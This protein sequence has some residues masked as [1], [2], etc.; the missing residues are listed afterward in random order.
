MGG[1]SL[2]AEEEVTSCGISGQ[3]HTGWGGASETAS[4]YSLS[5]PTVMSTS[6]TKGQLSELLPCHSPT[7]WQS[8]NMLEKR[9]LGVPY[10]DLT[11][12]VG[13]PWVACSHNHGE[14][15]GLS[16]TTEPTLCRMS[17]AHCACGP[18]TSVSAMAVGASSK[19]LYH[20]A[21]VTI[22]GHGSLGAALALSE[23]LSPSRDPVE[24]CVS[25]SG[26]VSLSLRL[27]PGTLLK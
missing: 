24:D 21:E 11:L 17:S 5:A 14:M 27:C 9:I 1:L 6:T 2:C 12:W 10:L 8:H 15:T 20:S 7:A 4:L 18:F 22:L 23:S 3:V 19:L 25:H 13:T 16:G 26:P